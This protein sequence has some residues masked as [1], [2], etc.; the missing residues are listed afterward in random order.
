MGQMNWEKL[1]RDHRF[2]TVTLVISILIPVLRSLDVTWFISVL[3]VFARGLVNV[4]AVG[5]LELLVYSLLPWI[6]FVA[7]MIK[8]KTMKKNSLF[9]VSAIFLILLITG[10]VL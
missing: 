4:Y 1:F 3:A 2:W 6:G 10:L 5:P 8:I 9:V 7:F